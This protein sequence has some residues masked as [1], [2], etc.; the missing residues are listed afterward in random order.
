M[1]MATKPH[2]AATQ[3]APTQSTSAAPPPNQGTTQQGSENHTGA[4]PV[5]PDNVGRLFVQQYYTVLNKAPNLLHRFY[6]KGSSFVHGKVDREG[7]AEEPVYGQNEIY[8]K[9]MTLDFQECYAKIRQVDSYATLGDGVVV[10]VTGE[11]STHGK[12]MRRFTQTFVLAPHS[13]RNYY[14]RNDIFRY[15]DEVFQENEDEEE[16]RVESD[17]ETVESPQEK[18]DS[19]DVEDEEEDTEGHPPLPSP[20]HPAPISTQE[21]PAVSP[22]YS[23]PPSTVSNGTNHLDSPGGTPPKVQHQ[24]DQQVE[25]GQEKQELEEPEQP[26]A[27]PVPANEDTDPASPVAPSPPPQQVSENHQGDVVDAEKPEVKEPAPPQENK[28]VSWA[29]RARQSPS[30]NSGVPKQAAQPTAQAASAPPAKST[31]N[32]GSSQAP[33]GGSQEGL[34]Q[35][36]PRRSGRGPGNWARRGPDASE[37]DRSRGGGPGRMYPDKCQL[38]V[39]NL[40]QDIKDDELKEFFSKY[41]NVVELRINRNSNPRLPFF[42]FVVF[43]EPGPVQYILKIRTQKPIL[44]REGYRLNVEEKKNNKNDGRQRGRGDSRPNSGGGPPHRGG[45]SGR[46]GGRGG[47]GVGPPRLGRGFNP[48]R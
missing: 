31:E 11:L 17:E 7:N 22:Y 9:I 39:G 35:R 10:Q 12:P 47:P 2:P 42:G 41:G 19:D 16:D 38:F 21:A 20:A 13:A 15:H 30:I 5:S 25:D 27:E 23:P 32:F 45:P 40:P 26:I 6:T 1:V 28:I 44:F 24:V 43:D 3:P 4:A 18:Q 14:V 48:P 37:G 36:E 8:L 46:G 29:D 34:P 33:R